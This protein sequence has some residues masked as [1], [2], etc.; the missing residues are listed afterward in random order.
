MTK[1]DAIKH[2]SY[3]ISYYKGIDEKWADS[4]N[5]DALEIAVRAMAQKQKKGNWIC[6]Y[7]VRCSNCNYK[8]EMTG[9]PSRCPSCGADMSGE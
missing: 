8:L 9:L 7:E 2:L 5:I 3:K 4:V 1:H 6:G